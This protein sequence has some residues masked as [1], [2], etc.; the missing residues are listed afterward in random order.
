MM[1]RSV[2]EGEEKGDGS[3]ILVVII[4]FCDTMMDGCR[5]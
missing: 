5:A 1:M 4:E 3:G 2:M